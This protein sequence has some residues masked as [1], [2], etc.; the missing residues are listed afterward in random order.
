MDQ[1][2]LFETNRETGATFSPCRTW[3][4]QLWRCW[5]PN[6]PAIMFVGLNPST[7]T[8]TVNDPTISKCIKFAKAWGYGTYLMCNL[9]G[10][11]S[12][13]PRG[14]DIVDDPIGP[15]NDAHIAAFAKQASKIVAA[16]GCDRQVPGRAKTVLKIL[17]KTHCLRI[18]K[19]GF[20]NHPLY[21]PDKTQ[22]IEYRD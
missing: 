20:P 22:L 16:W 7:A 13:D 19:G 8:E 17:G 12:T 6:L 1:K 3:R 2:S 14:L 10:F 21:M 18:T 5:D 15:E 4:Y 11:R 9:F